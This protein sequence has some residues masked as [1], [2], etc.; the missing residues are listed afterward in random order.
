M[1]MATS[2]TQL[3]TIQRG[4]IMRQQVTDEF[5]QVSVTAGTLQNVSEFRNI[6]VASTQEKGTGIILKPLERI[7][8]LED[9]TVYVRTF[10]DNNGAG[11]RAYFTTEPF[12]LKVGRGNAKNK[13]IKLTDTFYKMSDVYPDTYQTMTE[14]PDKLDTSNVTNMYCMFQGCRSL[15]TIPELDTSNVTTMQGMFSSCSKLTSIPNLDTNNVTTMEGMFTYCS[16]LTSIPNLDM[17][18]VTST[19]IMFMGC[20]GLTSISNLNMSKV[21]DMRQMFY[22][23]GNLTS[24]S[25]LDT[26]NVTNMNGTFQNCSKLTS[27][28]NLDTSN[29]RNMRDMFAGC[30]SLTTIPELDTSHV[31][32]MS[33]M[34]SRC[35]K[36]TSIPWHINCSNISSV[37]TYTSLHSIFKN[38]LV[39][40]V[41][42]TNVKEK[43]KSQIT[44]QYLKGDDTLEITFA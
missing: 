27:I 8:F 44:S 3:I 15:T 39:T 2:R 30:A 31:G 36:L 24:V 33:Y 18:N 23:C 13:A 6:E 21:T 34:F 10:G 37:S 4:E 35:S 29:A 9:T 26:S 28:S 12:K 32:D 17:S 41:T 22:L 20:S 19:V 16:K 42:L 7:Q 25:N 38:S 5:T 14:V 11:G 43:L 40:K 1:A